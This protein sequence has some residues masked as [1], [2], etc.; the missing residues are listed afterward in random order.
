MINVKTVIKNSQI[1][2]LFV[3]LLCYIVIIGEI[4][5]RI[6]THFFDIYE[7]EM[8]KYA[9]RLKRESN[10]TGLTHEHVPNT[11]AVLMNVKVK[12]NN[13]GFRDDYLQETKPADE[14]RILVIG[15]SMTMGWGVSFNSVYTTLLEKKLNL[16][17]DKKYNVI[18][19]GIGNYNASMVSIYL[20]MIATVVKPD[21][22]IF[23]YYLN[24]VELI[25]PKKANWMVKNSYFIALIYSR[26]LEAYFT[27]SVKYNSIGE[28]YYNLYDDSNKG[29]LSAQD[30]IRDIKKYCQNNNISFMIMI[31]P[32]LHDF[33]NGSYQA[34]CHEKIRLF[35]EKEGI[36]YLDIFSAFRNKLK[37]NPQELWVSKDDPHVNVAGHR[38]IYEALSEYLANSLR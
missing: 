33:S 13:M 21:K 4:L 36:E 24:D 14:Y 11:E 16:N 25:S 10:V 22:V 31:Q 37:N 28:Y 30:A 1:L 19:A 12:I 34:K 29:W 38:I 15:S 8:H 6:H 26:I 9:R 18:N 3:L 35:L 27:K 32:D 5:I 20:K 17:T 7:V 2:L 23:H